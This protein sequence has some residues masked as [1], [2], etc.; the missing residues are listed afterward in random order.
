MEISVN[1]LCLMIGG[2]KKKIKTMIDDL[3]FA[4]G[5]LL[6]SFGVYQIYIPA[7]YIVLGAFLIAAAVIW[8]KGAE[9]RK[10]DTE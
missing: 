4:A 8:T 5:A 2:F 7:G 9:G 10:Y 6:I 1:K 3:L